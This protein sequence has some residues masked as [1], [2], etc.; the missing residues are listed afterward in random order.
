MI[1]NCVVYERGQ[2]LSDIPLNEVRAHLQQRVRGDGGAV[3]EKTD[4]RRRDT[5]GDEFGDPFEHAQR[6]IARRARYLL[7]RKLARRRVEQNKIGV[8]ATHI[9]ADSVA[10][11]RRRS[12]TT[13]CAH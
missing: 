3:G 2:K 7:D 9:D 10:P 6:V 8:G 12:S 5:L 11:G 1:V 4:L 13:H